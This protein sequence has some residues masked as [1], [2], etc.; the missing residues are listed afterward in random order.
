MKEILKRELEKIESDGLSRRLRVISSAPDKDV[1]LAGKS[2]V[3][4]SSNN[5]LGLAVHPK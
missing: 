3:N 5:Y 1:V 2:Y 4:F